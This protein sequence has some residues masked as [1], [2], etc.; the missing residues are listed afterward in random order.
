M[1]SLKTKVWL[2]L[3]VLLII[4]VCVIVR[5][6]IQENKNDN[7]IKDGQ[8]RIVDHPKWLSTDYMNVNLSTEEKINVLNSMCQ[9]QISS[10]F[11]FIN[12]T[13][14]AGQY[15]TINYED[16]PEMIDSI[17]G[18]FFAENIKYSN[19][20]GDAVAEKDRY[21]Y[22]I[23]LVCE[24]GKQYTMFFTKDDDNNSIVWFCGEC[25]RVSEVIKGFGAKSTLDDI[26]QSVR[27]KGQIFER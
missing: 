25:F 1:R 20:S 22:Y 24:N 7:T 8:V 27:K 2:S 10:V 4:I 13:T 14:A 5:M 6:V 16:E 3:C 12:V 11:V 15:F 26:Y 9:T 23:T 19:C 18:V 21:D 17:K